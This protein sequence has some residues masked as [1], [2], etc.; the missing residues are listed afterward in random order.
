MIGV[1]YL[2]ENTTFGAEV[3]LVIVGAGA[4]GLAAG[5]AAKEGGVEVVIFERDAAPSG[6]TAMSSGFIPA[7]G[8]RHQR[9]LGVNDSVEMMERDIRTKNHDEADAAVVRSLCEASAGVIEWLSDRYGVPFELVEGFLYPGHSALRMHTTPGRSGAELLT[10]LVDAASR[11]DINVLT[12]AAVSHLYI[13]FD[14]RVCGV[15][16]TRPDGS[17]DSVR[18]EALLLACNGFGG[19]ADV[20]SRLIPA[21]KD[22]PYYGHAGNQGEAIL[23]GSLLGASLKDLGAFQ[24]HGS[25]SWPQQTLISWAAMMEGGI[26]VNSLG[27][28]FSNEHAGYSEQA[29]LIMA[30]PEGIAWNIFDERIHQDLLRSPDYRSAVEFGAVKRGEDLE[31]LAGVAGIPAACLG[32][33]FSEM[34]TLAASGRADQFGRLFKPGDLLQAPFYAVR[35]TGA[36][37]HTQGGLEIDTHG[38]VLSRDGRPMPNLY[39]VGGAARGISGSSCSGYLSG[40]GLLSATV[41]GAIAGRAIAKSIGEGRNE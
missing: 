37:F 18:C 32:D 39:A 8:T 29:L 5:L 19:N 41:M 14:R 33:V 26:Q 10:Y 38:R 30:Q 13:D 20:V 36:L 12:D 23:W 31:A 15:G 1:S 34:H 24:G 4:G 17:T 40:N 11:S 2:D 16:Y 27:T 7:A 25:L 6:S 35:V 3:P 21:M 9:A 22:A 28:R